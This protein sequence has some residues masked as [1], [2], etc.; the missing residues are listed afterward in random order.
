[1]ASRSELEQLLVGEGAAHMVELA[2]EGMKVHREV[3]AA[4]AALQK[5]ASDERFDLAVAS[6]FRDFTRQLYLWNA[7]PQGKRD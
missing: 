7:R 6:G 2:P 1:M 3:A 4:L 5:A